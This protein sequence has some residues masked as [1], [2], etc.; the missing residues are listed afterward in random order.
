M[1]RLTNSYCAILLKTDISFCNIC[2]F[3]VL[4]EGVASAIL[5]YVTPPIHYSFLLYP[6]REIPSL[7]RQFIYDLS[8]LLYSGNKMKKRSSLWY[9]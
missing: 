7:K 2:E 5:L 1:I 8:F 4:R 3:H 9:F 6:I